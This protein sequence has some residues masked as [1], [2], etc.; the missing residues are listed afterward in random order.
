MGIY[1]VAAFVIS[2]CNTRPFRM[3][4]AA[5]DHEISLGFL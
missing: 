3:L 5:R 4:S 2:Q 1:G